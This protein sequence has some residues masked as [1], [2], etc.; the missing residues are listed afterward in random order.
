MHANAVESLLNYIAATPSNPAPKVLDV[1]SGSG[2]LTHVIAE[3][4]GAQGQVIGIDHIQPLVD[5]AESNMSKSAEG[6]E[7]LKSGR[8]QFVC[9][10]GRKGWPKDALY[11]AIHVGAAA[12]EAH[13]ELLQQ[14]KSPGRLFIPVGESGGNQYIW[15]IDKD[16]DGKINRKRE[17]GVRYVPLTDAP[18]Q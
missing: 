4:V 1:G 15:V 18:G 8:V 5:L 6:K 12:R 2:Y 17:Y 10:D 14:L 7:L 3:L 11:D 13:E 16:K 9:G